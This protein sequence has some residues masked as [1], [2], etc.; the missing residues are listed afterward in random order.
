MQLA[1]CLFHYFPYGGL[2][3]DML[4]LARVCRARGHQ[5][6]IYTQRWEGAKPEDIPVQLVPVRAWSNHGRA[7]EFARRFNELRQQAAIDL[8]VGF[9][10][11]PG[12]DVYFAADTCFAQK[13]YEERPWF[14]RYSHRS[15]AYLALERAV[16]GP[17]SR[18][19]ILLIAPA[20]RQAF[21]RYYHTPAERLQLLPPG[22]RRDRI[23]P[24]DYPQQR[25]QLRAGYCLAGDTYV[26]LMVGSDF[27][28][29]GLARS[30]KALAALPQPLRQR[31]QLWVAGQ[32]DA[33]PYLQLAQQLGVAQQLKMLGARDDVAQL[34]WAADL[35]LHPAH[36][37]A[38][39]AV[40]L[41]AAVAG[42][43]VIA[44]DVC[45]YAHYI[46]DYQMGCI[47]AT[48]EVDSQ[49]AG[50]IQKIAA[51]DS[52]I[53]RD[54]AQQ[55]VDRGEVFAMHETAADLIEQLHSGS[56]TINH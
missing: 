17:A 35:L 40:L 42:L 21:Q 45:G 53:W 25:T 43:P 5:V 55:L 28:R 13:V 44:T 30:I 54:R 12:L 24:A 26:L 10:K 9:N 50:A 3:R 48:A 39:G 31:C 11:M 8:V 41:E 36:S 38:A 19:H 1:F 29:K 56:A 7:M 23:M 32:G 37:E 18:S 47:L 4:A 49:L 14:Y 51:E 33:R 2:E 34:M 16:F 20:Q 22:I 52:H 15:R 27:K 46:Q 6:T